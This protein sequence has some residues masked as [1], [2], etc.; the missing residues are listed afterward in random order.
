MRTILTALFLVCPVVFAQGPFVSDNFT[1]GLW[2]FDETFGSIVTDASSFDNHA[3]VMGATVVPGRFGN[4]RYFNGESDYLYVSDPPNGSLNFRNDE[5]FTIEVWFKTESSSE[6]W[7]FGKGLAP[8]P[9]YE[10]GIA[11]GRIFGVVGNREDGSSPDTLLRILSDDAYNDNQWHHAV[12][13]RDRS[14]RKLFLYVDD[15]LA[16]APINDSFPLPLT[17]DAPLGIGRWYGKFMPLYFHGALD[18]IRI[19]STTRHPGVIVADTLGLWDLNE[20]TGTSIFDSSPLHN[21][22]TANGSTIVG[23]VIRSARY[24]DGARDHASMPSHASYNF[25]SSESFTVRA[26]IRTTSAEGTILCRGLQPDPGF[27]LSINSGRAVGTIGNRKGR[28]WK[29]TLL[30]ITS[31]RA[32]NDDAW[33]EVALIRDRSLSKLFLYVD[34]VLAADPQVDNFASP[35]TSDRPLVLAA[36]S[37]ACRDYFTGAIDE[38]GIFAGARHPA[39]IVSD[40]IAMWHFDETTGTTI[41]DSSP[42]RNHGTISGTSVVNG[43]LGSARHFNGA[44]SYAA[45]ASDPC[46][47]FQSSESFTVSLWVKTSAP[48]GIILRKGLDPTPGF[49]ISIHYGRAIA[50]IGNS[51]GNTWSDTLLT[52]TSSQR[53]DDN[54]WHEIRM[55]RD[56]DVRKLFLYVDGISAATPA[57]DNFAIPLTSDRFLTIGSSRILPDFFAGPIDEVGIFRG[58]RHP[59]TLTGDTLVCYHFD[60]RS[61]SSV[62]DSSPNSHHGRAY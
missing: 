19:S 17:N 6:Q 62:F 46:Y 55:I 5:S 16:T 35:L 41:F 8:L 21:H 45:I 50:R 31:N 1:A 9:G 49:Q 23:G 37:I 44:N 48:E 53:I 42:C 25:H 20:I 34:G 18:E 43:A 40:T 38:V 14:L 28:S 15:L 24:F 61:G 60:E 30:S 56:R 11:E 36:C 29:D 51:R 3:L 4:A 57:E 26:W 12:L 2:H 13:I 47:S 39:P 22:G 59:V 27:Q 52:L 54:L 33:H 32:V 7:I 10:L 58:A